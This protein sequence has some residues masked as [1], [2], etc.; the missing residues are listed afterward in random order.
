[1]SKNIWLQKKYSF[2]RWN[3]LL[4]CFMPIIK[5]Q[6]EAINDSK[7]KSHNNRPKAPALPPYLPFGCFHLMNI[8]FGIKQKSQMWSREK[9][10]FFRPKLNQTHKLF[11]RALICYHFLGTHSVPYVSWYALRTLLSGFPPAR[12]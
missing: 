2:S 8:L 3:I 9:G 5:S 11:I 6:V 4:F 1:M 12:E 10:R 7:Q